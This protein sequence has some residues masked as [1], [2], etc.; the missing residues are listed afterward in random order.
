MW[1]SI[2]IKEETHKKL[3]LIKIQTKAKNLDAVINKVI[4]LLSKETP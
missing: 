1:K 4:K 2:Q 3:M